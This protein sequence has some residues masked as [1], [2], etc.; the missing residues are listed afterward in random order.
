VLIERTPIDVL[1]GHV[2]RY[3]GFVEET[4]GPLRR[5]EGPGADVVLVFSLDHDWLIDGER[6]TS[7]TGGLR[8]DQVTTEHA[9]RSFGLQ[10]DLTPFAARALLGVP[11]H[12]LA[13]RVVPLDEPLLVEQ[14]ADAPDWEARFA[15][16]DRVLA[17]RVSAPPRDVAWAWTRLRE[18]HGRVR[19]GEL[20]TEL[21]W[22]RKRLVAQFRD[23][24]GLPPKAVAKLLRFERARELAGTMPWAELAVECGY[25]D[26]SHLSND[27][28][29]VTGRT[30]ETFFQD[31]LRDA[32]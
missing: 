17:E 21:G 11:M 6:Y 24:V 16:L 22:S 7:F 8:E 4:G 25:Y 30:P 15:L 19:V 14:L 27:F 29:A 13:G 26:Q 1:R 31:S 32:A 18:T 28:R 20:A 3:C 23:H 12:E 10:V 9:G 5:R 2:T